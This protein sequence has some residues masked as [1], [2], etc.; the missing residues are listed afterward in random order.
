MQKFD[1]IGLFQKNPNRECWK[2]GISRGVSEKAVEI[3][4]S[5]KKEVQFPDVFKKN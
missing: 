4:G 1:V 2:L 5:I 3:P